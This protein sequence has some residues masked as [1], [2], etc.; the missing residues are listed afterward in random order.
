MSEILYAKGE[1]SGKDLVVTISGDL[2]GES[3]KPLFRAIENHKEDLYD[4][5]I[6]DLEASQYI[7]SSGIALL[8]SLINR[9]Q[10]Q[11]KN[12]GIRSANTQFRKII[13]TVGLT[14]FITYEN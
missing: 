13:D 11:K 7:N 12:L 4:K 10:E 2:S 8:I 9:L 1:L 5:V 3:E 14:E 6:L